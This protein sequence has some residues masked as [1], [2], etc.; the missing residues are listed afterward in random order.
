MGL[1][2][3]QTTILC[4]ALAA[5]PVAWQWNANRVALKR[6]VAIQSRLDTIHDQQAR[7]STE[8]ERL[9]AESVRLDGALAEA[10]KTQARYDEAARKLEVLKGR[11]RT[12]LADANYHWPG[13]LPYVRV[14]KAVIKS[15]DLLH[16]PPMAFGPSGALTEPALELFA[17]TPQEKAPTE[18]ALA[19]YWRG[20]EDLMS[21]NAYETNL[22]SAQTGRLTK[23]VIVPPLGQPLKA[24]AEDTRGQLTAALDP[25]REQL[26]FAGWDEGAIQIFSPGNLWK[27]S[28]E[29]QTFTVWVEP[30][31]AGGSGPR[32]GA[33]RSSTMG[34]TSAHDAGSLGI[35]PKPIA[36]RFFN[37]WLEQ[38][39]I[40]N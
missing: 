15:L 21:A 2:K 34:G 8:L 32:Y 38:F 39:G 31:G 22:A 3:A 5:A 24:L 20:V 12:M 29:P 7:S 9:L 14:P 17:I 16:R 33:S 37:S 11:V 4:V 26:L 23:T 18:A 19:N 30:A 36:V 13:D 10:A 27:I 35:V 40:T 6:A 1:T 28:E 25:E